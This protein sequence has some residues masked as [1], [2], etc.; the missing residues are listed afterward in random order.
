MTTS[1]GAWRAFAELCARLAATPG[2]LAKRAAIAAYLQ[3]LGPSLAGTAAQYLT[4]NPFAESD[5]RSL[6]VGGQILARALETVSRATPTAFQAAYRRYGDLGAAAELLLQPLPL[7]DPRISI[8]EIAFRFA[9]MAATRLQSSRLAQL[10]DLLR[11]LS[12]LE[13]KYAIKLMLGDMRIGV[14]QSLVE[15]AIAQATAQDVAEVRHAVALQGDL[16]TVTQ[17]AWSH[18]LHTARLRMFHSLGFMLATPAEGAPQAYSR[19]LVPELQSAETAALPEVQI[20]DKYDGMRAQIHCGDPEQPG[21]VRIFSRTR[22]DVTA[23]FPELASWFASAQTP[24]ILDGEILAWDFAAERALPFT[25]LQPRLGRNHVT[26]ALQRQTPVLFMA[27]DLL[28]SG[29]RLLLDAPLRERRAHL[30]SW[31]AAA[32]QSGALLADAAPRVAAQASLFDTDPVP[33]VGPSWPRLKLA[34]AQRMASPQQIEDA[35]LAA[36]GRGNEGLMLKALDSRYQPGRRGG[37]WTKVKREL[38]TLDVVVTAVEYGHGKRAGVLSDYTFAVRNGAEL[39]N[40]GKAYSGLTDREILALTQ[41]FLEH[42]V[43][44]DGRLLLVEPKVVLEVAFNNVMRSERHGSGYSLR[45]PRILRIRTDK[46]AEQIDTV[47][48]VR[49]I[50]QQQIETAAAASRDD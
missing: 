15:E 7:P 6:Q 47:A 41:W 50:F 9:R 10:I 21:R 8:D 24:A 45:F 42:T 32:L 30:E 20:E 40:V 46:P 5:S 38:A 11:A 39:Q 48:R 44:S 31:C 27:F 19:Y 12:P 35:F 25:A 16:A 28:L 17:L 14:R 2:K 49:E 13:A 18:Q 34:P 37:A 23:S 4:G 22:E 26:A 43:H 3:T 36:R 33:N 1:P 29:S